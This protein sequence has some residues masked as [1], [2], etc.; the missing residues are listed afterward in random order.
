VKVA[1]YDWPDGEKVKMCDVN[2]HLIAVGDYDAQGK[3]LH[4]TVVLA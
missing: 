2:D 1:E 4:P 3:H